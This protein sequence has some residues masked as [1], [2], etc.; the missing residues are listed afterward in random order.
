LYLLTNWVAVTNS[1]SIPH[2]VAR[3][4]PSLIAAVR[5]KMSKEYVD[6]A[7][8]TEPPRHLSRSEDPK[9]F[10]IHPGSSAYSH[11]HHPKKPS[12]LGQF[13]KPSEAVLPTK[14]VV[15]LPESSPPHRLKLT[16]DGERLRASMSEATAVKMVT[17]ADSSISSECFET[18]VSLDS[19]RSFGL[20]SSRPQPGISPTGLTFPHTPS[21]PSSPESSIMIIGSNVQ[22]SSSFLHPKS[23]AKYEDKGVVP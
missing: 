18:S 19:S 16:G 12:Q 6:Q 4:P 2:L 22:V 13:S 3:P 7:V 20:Y 21:P 15:S 17:E 11:P 8:Q 14:R 23:K 1:L 5:L 9:A 10:H